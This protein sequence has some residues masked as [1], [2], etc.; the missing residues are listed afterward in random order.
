MTLSME[1]IDIHLLPLIP[2][3]S[4]CDQLTR[5][6]LTNTYWFKV[7]PKKIHIWGFPI[8]GGSPIAGW[9]IRENPNLQWMMKWG[10]PILGN[11]HMNYHEL[12]LSK[13]SKHRVSGIPTS[14][15]IPW[16][17]QKTQAQLRS[18]AHGGDEPRHRSTSEL[19]HRWLGQI[20]SQHT[21]KNI[22]KPWKN[23]WSFPLMS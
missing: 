1:L 16:K 7:I 14:S 3:I 15:N 17:A 11:L 9:F 6:F 4:F 13:N 10:T 19:F 20:S 22:K 2:R 12:S 18:A 8:N 21:K 5:K 23:I